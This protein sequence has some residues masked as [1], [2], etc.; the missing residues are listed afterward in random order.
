MPPTS[1]KVT[2]KHLCKTFLGLTQKQHRQIAVQLLSLCLWHYFGLYDQ[3]KVC[4]QAK[5]TLHADLQEPIA[6]Q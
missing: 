3:T 5:G 6:T 2:C 1:K 4:I